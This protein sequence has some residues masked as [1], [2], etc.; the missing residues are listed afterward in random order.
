M[1]TTTKGILATFAPDPQGHPALQ[2]HRTQSA[3]PINGT[4]SLLFGI[5]FMAAGVF[6]AMVALDRAP[7]RRH[8]PDWLIG[9]LAFMFFLGGL[10]FFVHGLRDIARKAAC[11][12]EATLRPSEPW[13]YDHHWQREG[14]A[15]S[16]FDDMLKRLMAALVW[17]VFLV[18]FGWVGTNV[19][20]A[21]P[22]L[23]GTVIFGLIGLIFWFRWAA[24][25]L[26]LLRYGNS[27]LFYEDFPF[28]LGGALRARLRAPRHVS[29]IDEL[30]LTLRCVQERYVTTGTGRN[31]STSVVCYELYKDMLSFDRDNLT[32]LAGGDIPIEFRLPP[33]QP[34]TN[35]IAR[36]PIYWE[37]EAKGKARGA[38]YEAAFLVPV[39]KVS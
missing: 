35:L 3:A 18:P 17:T 39:Y 14:M 27:F 19:R 30:T 1:A 37:I 12:R 29:A 2:N 4:S 33:D 21:W 22:F 10:F 8:A 6:I 11:R 25:L 24:M 5:P 38:D 32:G 15:F 31:R 20:G 13:L 16:A 26:D 7:A 23:A 34:T 28:S 9:I 36:P